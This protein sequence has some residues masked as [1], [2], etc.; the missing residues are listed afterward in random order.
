MTDF[1]QPEVTDIKAKFH[2]F[3]FTINNYTDEH[4]EACNNYSCVYIIYAKEVGE[5]GT[6]HLQGYCELKD[7]TTLSAIRKHFKKIWVA[8]R[9]GTQEQA[10]TYCKKDNDFVERGTPKAQGKRTD[11]DDVRD[12]IEKGVSKR[13][14]IKTCQNPSVIN[15]LPTLIAAYVPERTFKTI[16]YWFWGAPG[17]GKSKKAH[18]LANKLCEK[19]C[20]NFS[21]TQSGFC[22]GY[23]GQDGIII[24]DFDEKKFDYRWILNFL[25]RYPMILN[26]KNGEIN[27]AARIVFIT[28]EWPHTKVYK[29]C[30]DRTAWNRRITYTEKFEP[31]GRPSRRSVPEV[32]GNNVPRLRQMYLNAL[33]RQKD[34]LEYAIN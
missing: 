34:S 27:M 20:T 17:T 29:N 4:I 28:C 19:T 21:I 5:Q 10:I 6:P 1:D 33:K 22:L 11:I 3:V 18:Y 25:D 13:E 26:V 24:D 32:G 31:V 14:I 30:G 2:N 23:E 15:L 7:R 12:M 16:V 9:R 8:N